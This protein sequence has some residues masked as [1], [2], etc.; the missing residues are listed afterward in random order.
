[1][2]IDSTARVAPCISH[3]ALE[4]VGDPGDYHLHEREARNPCEFHNMNIHSVARLEKLR[5]VPH[6]PSPLRFPGTDYHEN[7][8]VDNGD[9]SN[10]CS[11]R[12]M[13]R[14]GDDLRCPHWCRR[15][16]VQPN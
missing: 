3:E 1:M 10:Y 16:L 9:V 2:R 4:P 7:H 14:G 8:R 6:E 15:L 11:W 13:T 5:A 12:T